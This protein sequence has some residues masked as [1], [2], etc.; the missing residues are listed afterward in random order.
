MSIPITIFQYYDKWNN[1]DIFI[2]SDISNI[3]V[4][5]I[6]V[7]NIRFQTSDKRNYQTGLKSLTRSVSNFF[8][9]LFSSHLFFKVRV[10]IK[11]FLIL[12]RETVN[13]KLPPRNPALKPNE[14]NPSK[15]E[16]N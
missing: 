12:K 1:I 6:T 4:F 14:S 11:A 10:L 2:C 7:F 13:V 5:Y 16:N 15:S 9:V 8:I 3:A